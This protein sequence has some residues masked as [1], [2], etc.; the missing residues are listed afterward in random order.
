MQL[1]AANNSKSEVK[2]ASVGI[3]A[4]AAHTG[5]HVVTVR[6]YARQGIIRGKNFLGRRGWVF[7]SLEVVERALAAHFGNAAEQD[8]LR[9]FR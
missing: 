1:M 8:H 2:T 9:R 6:R 5:L 3:D 7:P 4:V